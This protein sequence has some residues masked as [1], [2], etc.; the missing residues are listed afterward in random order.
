MPSTVTIDA[1]E[2]TRFVQSSFK[3]KGGGLIFYI[4][5]HKLTEKEVGGEKAD[6]ILITH[7]HF[8]HLD[9]AAI[10][11]CSKADTVI[12]ANAPC[13]R[14]IANRPNIVSL[15]EGE[16]TIQKGVSILTVPGYND[17]H[18]RSEGFN[19]GFAFNLD[20]KQIL[21]SGDTG[22]IPELSSLGSLDIAMVPIGGTYT[23]DEDEA[24]DAVINMLKPRHAIPMHYGYATGGDPKRFQ[25]LV[26][27]AA[28][29]HIVDPLLKIKVG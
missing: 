6:I 7:P 10:E 18:K 23:M 8:D 11:A 12:V 13:V 22:K 5:P 26:G 27:G 15:R 20:G 9:P 17:Y 28:K 4:D 14:E 19:V 16:S 24:A 29:V 1:I 3:I 25:S 21:H 2:F